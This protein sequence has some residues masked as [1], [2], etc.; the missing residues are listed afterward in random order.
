MLTGL[1]DVSVTFKE[2]PAQDVA[3]GE[4]AR[5]V[6]SERHRLQ[7]SECFSGYYL[8]RRTPEVQRARVTLICTKY[9]ILISLCP[10]ISSGDIL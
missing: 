7:Q 3:R 9:R 2:G 4:T 5:D 8:S 6:K 10:T 1:C